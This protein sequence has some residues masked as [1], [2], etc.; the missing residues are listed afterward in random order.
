MRLHLL[1]YN[2]TV[3]YKPGKF[4]YLADTLSRAFLPEIGLKSDQEFNFAVHSM[5]KD[6]AMSKERKE[7]FRQEI[8]KDEVL[9]LVFN[10]PIIRMK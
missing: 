2:N 7:Q 1:N 9:K 6:L 8:L 3:N 5:S 4:L 10:F